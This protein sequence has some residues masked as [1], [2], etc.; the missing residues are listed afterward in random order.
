MTSTVKKDF[1]RDRVLDKEKETMKF[2]KKHHYQGRDDKRREDFD[3]C[4]V[5][6]EYCVNEDRNRV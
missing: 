3:E 6:E 1:L 4:V 5:D 2:H